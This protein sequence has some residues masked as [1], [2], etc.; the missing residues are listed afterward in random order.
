ML[1]IEVIYSKIGLLLSLDGHLNIALENVEELLNEQVT[2][3]Y[4]TV[5]LRGNNGKDSLNTV[6]LINSSQSKTNK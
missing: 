5:F 6:F 3:R 4:P 1:N 2:N